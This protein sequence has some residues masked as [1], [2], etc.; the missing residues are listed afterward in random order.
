MTDSIKKVGIVGCGYIAGFA[1]DSGR[2][3]HIYTHA[4]ALGQV[5]GAQLVACCDNSPEQA[6]KFAERWNVPK[7][8]LRLED[9]L[10]NEAL[11]IL[12]VATPTEFHHDNVTEALNYPIKAIFCEK[13]LASSLANAKELAQKAK[14]R[15]IPL[16]VNF[17][18]RW[19]PFYRECKDILASGELGRVET[20]VVYVDTALFMNAIHMLDLLLYFAG[21]IDIVVGQLDRLNEARIVHG[22][23]DPGGFAFIRHQSGIISF[24]KATGESRRNYFFELDFQCTKGRLRILD[25]DQKYEIYKFKECEEKNWL[26]Q[27]SLEKTVLN[28]KKRERV[29][30]AYHNIINAIDQN[31]P[32]ASSGFESLKVMELIELIY[33]SDRQGQ[34]PVKSKL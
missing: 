26:S 22:K 27:L 2:R 12:T 13:P 16:A 4:K 34:L 1:D 9:M 24:I 23:A 31:E 15:K 10:K 21:D 29:V 20:I 19:D 7:Q 6:K 33:E 3:R 18:R 32:L 11:D 17:M 30:A 25:D 5:P 28:D 14:E 8:Y